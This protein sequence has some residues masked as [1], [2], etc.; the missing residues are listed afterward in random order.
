[1]EG[2]VMKK[3][4]LVPLDGST[5]AEEALPVAGELAEGLDA[6]LE[7]VRVVPPPVPS[8]FYAPRLREQVLEA[9]VAEAEAYLAEVAARLRGDRLQVET[10]VLTGEAARA[11]TRF[12]E[13]EHCRLIVMGS[14]GMG[15]LGSQVFGSVA[16]KVLHTAGCPVL[17]VRPP[18]EVLEREEEAEELQTD[19]AL[20]GALGA[21]K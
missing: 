17:T 15:G 7:L 16:Q 2:K 12:A 18:P 6:A 10:H 14:H 9:Q 1:M 3:R 21:K 8:R 20:L 4:I 13:R 11:L 5:L 19:A